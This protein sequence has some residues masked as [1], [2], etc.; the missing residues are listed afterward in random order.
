MG[1]FF[2][3]F[4]AAVVWRSGAT[5]YGDL[6]PLLQDCVLNLDQIS[7]VSFVWNVSQVRLNY[8][9]FAAPELL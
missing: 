1:V 3:H 4:G 8:A 2:L 7:K 6:K 5:S 9:L